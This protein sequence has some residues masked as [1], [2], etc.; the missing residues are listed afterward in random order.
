MS[1]SP[2]VYLLS[3]ATSFSSW[4]LGAMVLGFSPTDEEG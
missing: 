4:Q 2:M 1:K 3:I